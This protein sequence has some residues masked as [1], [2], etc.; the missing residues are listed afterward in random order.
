MDAT[1]LKKMNEL[2]TQNRS[3]VVCTVV[4]RFGSTPRDIGAKMLVLSDE[5][6]GSIGGGKIE[7][8][9]IEH[10]KKMIEKSIAVDLKEYSLL[11]GSTDNEEGM[12]CGGKLKVFFELIALNPKLYVF[13]AGHIGYEVAHLGKDAGFDVVV[14]DDRGEYANKDRF[15]FA[16]VLCVPIK[17]LFK[18]IDDK[19]IVFDNKSYIVIVTRNHLYDADILGKVIDSDAKYIGMIGSLKKVSAVFNKLEAQGIP[20]DLLKKVYSPIGLDISAQT[21]FEI[22]ISII[23]EIIAVRRNSSIL[24]KACLKQRCSPIE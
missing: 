16:K 3:F 5:I 13:G 7:A 2:L 4:E 8:E 24:K 6:Y 9:V 14:W 15:P 1:L 22:A 17:D 19:K 23:A 21:P 20:K 11:D 18:L 10:A 12:I